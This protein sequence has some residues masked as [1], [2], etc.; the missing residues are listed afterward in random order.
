MFVRSFDLSKLG[1]KAILIPTFLFF[2]ADAALSFVFPVFIE[3]QLQS[4]TAV[5]LIIAI[6]S[7][8]AFTCDI[9]FPDLLKNKSWKSDFILAILLAITFSITLFLGVQFGLVFFIIASLAWGVFWELIGFSHED[10]ILTDKNK[11]YNKDWAWIAITATIAMLAGTLL[12]ATMLNMSLQ[13]ALTTILTIQIIGTLTFLAITHS[14]TI[15]EKNWR[16]KI[17]IKH[18]Y[19]RLKDWKTKLREVKTLIS[20]VFVRANI[21]ATYWTFAALLGIS[22]ASTNLEW[23]PLT[24]YLATMLLGGIIYTQLDIKQPIR[25]AKYGLI[26]AGVLLAA[27]M[28]S[29]ESFIIITILLILSNS[30]LSFITPSVSGAYS[31][32]INKHKQQKEYVAMKRLMITTAWIIAPISFGIIADQIG[33]INMFATLGA[34][35][36]ITGTLIRA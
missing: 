35:S 12:G 24:T 36:A 23:V 9:I 6:S 20:L 26:I 15:Q 22:I 10:Y 13:A 5:G 2:L 18:L 8:A 32:F 33:Y 3:R 31:Q 28:F 19:K 14:L 21:E 27:I 34:I 25:I 16:Y 7:L 30:A 17:R 1:F 11:Q 29:Q 4:N